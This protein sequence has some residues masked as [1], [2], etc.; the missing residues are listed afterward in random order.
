MSVPYKPIM[1]KT[2]LHALFQLTKPKVVAVMLISSLIGMSLTPASYHQWDGM[3]FGLIGIALASAGAATLNHLF[4]SAIDVKMSRTH[5]RPMAQNQLTSNE[6]IGFA[7]GLLILSSFFLLR[8]TNFIAWLTSLMTTVGYAWLYTQWLKPS[9]PQNIVIGGLSGAMPP[10]LGW[11][12][13][14]PNFDLEP[15]LLTLIIFLWT[16]AHFWPLAIHFK[17]DYKKSGLPMLPVTHGDRF[18][19][20]CIMAYTLLSFVACL[21]PYALGL[22]G[23]VYLAVV[24]VINSRWLW[25]NSHL[26]FRPS[27][28]MKSF[29]F[30]IHYLMLLFGVILVDRLLIAI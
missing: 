4:E 2:K 27:W 30:S 13:L 26:F 28:H 6:V 16:P 22:F 25:L 12:C 18:T 24:V 10:L 11:L 1:F 7:S 8:Y 21:I 14:K 19:Q 3:I 20:I 29:R 9:T 17:E 5:N 23:P 15:T